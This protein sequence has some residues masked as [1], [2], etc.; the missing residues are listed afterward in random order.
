MTNVNTISN[1]SSVGGINRL[2]RCS[3]KI[4]KTQERNLL[5]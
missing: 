2:H 4:T 3:G 1:N 5:K